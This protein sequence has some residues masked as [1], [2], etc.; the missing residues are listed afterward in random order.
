MFDECLEPPHVERPVTPAP[1]GPVLVNSVGTPSSTS[2]DQDA[3]SPSH[4]PSYSALYSPCLHLGVVVESTLMDEN[5]FAPADND[6][7]INIFALEPTSEASSSGD[8]SSTKSTYEEV[9]VSQLEGFVNPDHPTH[10]YRLKKALY[11]LKQDPQA[12]GNSAVEFFSLTVAKCSSSV[13]I[14]DWQWG[15]LRVI[16]CTNGGKMH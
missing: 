10:V 16:Y 4:S 11:G 12:C 7:F 3:P 5:P 8:A 9:Y 13:I 6:P 15:F 2:I 14:F 1:T